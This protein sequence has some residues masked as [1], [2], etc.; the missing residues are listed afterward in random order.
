M[1]L[2]RRDP[3]YLRLSTALFVVILLNLVIYFIS[4]KYIPAASNQTIC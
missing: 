4:T 1:I 3:T 2:L